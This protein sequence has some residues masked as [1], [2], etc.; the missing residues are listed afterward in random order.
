MVLVCFVALVHL[1]KTCVFVSIFYSICEKHGTISPA[2]LSPVMSSYTLVYVGAA[3]YSRT[4]L[5]SHTSSETYC[6]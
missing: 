5:V 3:L 6:L 1:D 2:E 4:G